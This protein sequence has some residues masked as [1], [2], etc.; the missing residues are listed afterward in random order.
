[1]SLLDF[2]ICIFLR[3]KNKLCGIK[4]D[5]AERDT[6]T[7]GTYL[8]HGAPVSNLRKEQEKFTYEQTGRRLS[9]TVELKQPTNGIPGSPALRCVARE[10]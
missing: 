4:F 3:I 7:K 8:S 6:G 5:K 2:C 9:N 10:S 1:M